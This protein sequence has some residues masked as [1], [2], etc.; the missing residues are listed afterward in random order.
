MILHLYNAPQS[1]CS[2]RVRF[3]LHEKGLP[4]TETLLDLFRGDQLEPD[5]LKLNPNGVVPTLMVDGRPI[6]DSSVIME[7]LDEVH[8]DDPALVPEDPL[9][10]S[11]MRS[12]MRFF[13]EV[14]TPAVRVPSYNVVFKRHFSAMSEEEFRAHAESKPLRKD[15]LLAMGRE[16]FSDAEVDKAYERLKRAVQRMARALKGGG[17]WL[18]GGRLTLADVA[19]LPVIVRMEDLGLGHFWA[20]QPRVSAGLDELKLRP[21]FEQTFYPGTLVSEKYPDLGLPGIARPGR[22]AV[23]SLSGP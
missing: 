14:P 8:R 23:Q 19:V 11:D 4:F 5:Y 1:T 16:G 6:I 22:E 12:L 21:A 17:P 2:Q 13:D 3:V 10:R 18:L 9:D 7:Y 15:F 20:E